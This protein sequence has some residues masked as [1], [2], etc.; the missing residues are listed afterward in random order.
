MVAPTITAFWTGLIGLLGLALAVNVVRL[1]QKFGIG[2]G[3]GGHMELTRAIRVFGNFAEYAA[4]GLVMVGLLEMVGGWSWLIHVFGAALLIGR[5][6]HAWGLAHSG[7]PSIGRVGGM[8]LT[9]FV[10]LV[11]S[12]ML[13]WTARGAIL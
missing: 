6:A 8:V 7:G 10:L 3:D 13:I 9:W 1:R 11:G 5:A 12:V 4:I 2:V